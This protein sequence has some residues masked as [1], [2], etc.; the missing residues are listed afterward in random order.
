MLS[1]ECKTEAM[2]LS[3]Y[4]PSLCGGFFSQ[5]LVSKSVR[6]GV[7]SSLPRLENAV[8][9]A[10]ICIYTWSLG[11]KHRYHTKQGLSRQASASTSLSETIPARL[12]RDHFHID[13]PDIRGECIAGLLHHSASRCML[14]GHKNVSNDL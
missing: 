7:G 12:S 6:P 4:D 5:H 1:L 10:E 9:R 11:Q 2:L 8:V 13:Y 3:A 14:S